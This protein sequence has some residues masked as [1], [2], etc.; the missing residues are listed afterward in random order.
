[1]KLTGYVLEDHNEMPWAYTCRRLIEE[2]RKQGDDLRLIGVHETC[3]DAEGIYNDGRRLEERDYLINRYKWNNVKD[4]V[5]K[6]CKLSYNR[7]DAF[8]IYV[9][10]Y[11]QL[12]RLDLK[13]VLTPAYVL[14]TA[15]LDHAFIAGK[16][17][18]PFVAKGL[19]SSMGREVFLIE[20]EEDQK[21]L[22]TEYGQDREWLFE[23]YIP[24][25]RCRDMRL[26]SV[27]G[28]VIACMERRSDDDF[29]ANVA[30]GAKV[31][32][33]KVTKVMRD[34]AA[35]IY[36]KTG[37]DFLGIDLLYGEDLP[38][39]CEINVMPGIKGMEEA[40]GVNVA[41]AMIDTIRGDF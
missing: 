12:K 8:N 21:K 18:L 31:Y 6:L 19:C 7:I 34:V 3:M 24:T 36:E 35:E 20:N 26:F 28:E 14:G 30:L 4:Y 29:R 17:G 5:N 41:C 16:L 39:F 32:P 38:Y 25:T 2:A 1:M 27:R 33:L 15:L 22:I 10:K 23:E 13:S 40:T 9:S 11:E 37:L